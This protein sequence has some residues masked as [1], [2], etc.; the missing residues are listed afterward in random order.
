MDNPLEP[1]I[2]IV[3]DSTKEQ[4][5]TM[6]TQERIVRDYADVK[7]FDVRCVF[8]DSGKSAET[9]PF[10]KREVAAKAL[11]YCREHGIRHIIMPDLD[12]AFRDVEDCQETIRLLTKGENSD[13]LSAIN[14]TGIA[15]TVIH[16]IEN[17]IDSRDEQCLLIL[18]IRAKCAEEATRKRS[19]WI[20]EGF[21]VMRKTNQKCGKQVPFGWDYV[22]AKSMQPIES[23]VP[24]G[25]LIPNPIEQ[26]ILTRLVHGDLSQCSLGDA[27]RALNAE[28]VKTKNAGQ[29]MTR[30]G[31]TWT[32]EGKW[33]ECTVSTL[34]KNHR[35][36]EE[37]KRKEE[38]PRAGGKRD[39]KQ[40]PSADGQ[41]QE[42][43]T[44]SYAQIHCPACSKILRLTLPLQGRLWNCPN[45][46]TR[47]SVAFDSAGHMATHIKLPASEPS[48]NRP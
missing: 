13:L 20:K 5:N 42:T 33:T 30:G 31:K 45:C 22:D 32:I 43:A 11:T 4:V 14:V 29:K 44:P 46:K 6:S 18:A 40:M 1:A 41:Q 3:R 23:N 26:R 28:G 19:K 15:G 12:H 21:A 17:G 36:A 16:I 2:A 24:G 37:Q 25:I 10:L 39:A 27:R 47:F 48:L 9:I 8:E 35:L 34:R 38:V 7:R